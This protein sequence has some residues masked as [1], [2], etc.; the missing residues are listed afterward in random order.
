MRRTN[1]GGPRPTHC[2]RT[3]AARPIGRAFV[4]IDAECN[5]PGRRARARGTA[6]STNGRRSERTGR[7]ED[8]G[9]LMNGQAIRFGRRTSSTRRTIEIGGA[10]HEPIQIRQ[11]A[12]RGR[13]NWGG[14]LRPAGAFGALTGALG[15]HRVVAGGGLDVPIR[16][17]D[18]NVVAA[19]G[20]RSPGAADQCDGGQKR[21]ADR[22]EH[23]GEVGT[24]HRGPS[25]LSELNL[26]GRTGPGQQNCRKAIVWPSARL[27]VHDAR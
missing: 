16:T 13:G 1:W 10:C 4:T 19:P 20:V 15:R 27:P 3:Q 24:G 7:V 9:R 6:R 2:L 5:R 21:H 26:Q 11:R 17:D 8:R 25:N 14:G 23:A 18:L 12:S 22:P